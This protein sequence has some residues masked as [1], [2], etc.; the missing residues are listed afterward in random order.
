MS[1]HVA[2][3]KGKEPEGAMK[4][5]QRGSAL[6]IVMVML[7]A[8]AFLGMS[9]LETVMHDRQSSGFHARKTAAFHAADAGIATVHA[10]VDG[11]SAP[12]IPNALLG[13]AGLYPHGQPSFG[14]DP[15]STAPVL[16]LGAVAARG[17]NLRIT[18]GGP[19]YQV[20]YWRF[21]VQGTA[22]GGSVSR[23]ELAAGVLRGN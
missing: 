7:V 11:V 4:R 14:P 20:Q 21:Q 18:G 5:R 2:E 23:V 22:P 17:M 8:L 19:R 1:A 12:V 6:L 15:N 3:T 13:D 9:T 16:D 10:Q